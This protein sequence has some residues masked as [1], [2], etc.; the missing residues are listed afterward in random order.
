MNKPVSQEVNFSIR[1]ILHI[2]FLHKGK[3]IGFFLTVF[4]LNTVLTLVKPETY[5][6]YSKLLI[7]IGRENVSKDP[8]VVGDTFS[9]MQSYQD[10]VNSELAILQSQ[11]LAEAVVDEIGPERFFEKTDRAAGGGEGGGEPP[12][13]L[14]KTLE[15]IVNGVRGA[16][17]N[18]LIALNLAEA[19]PVR[20]RALK[21]FEK[22]LHVEVLEDTSI[23]WVSFT[24]LTP[25]T[26]QDTL[27]ALIQ[28]FLDQH[29]EVHRTQASPVFFEAQV[30]NVMKNLEDKES[31]LE[32]FRAENEIASLEIQKNEIIAQTGNLQNLIDDASGKISSYR[33]KVD[34]LE[35][36]LRRFPEKRQ[37]ATVEGKI[38]A[39]AATIK[40]K[41]VE[42][43]L[44]EAE[45][46]SK[47]QEDYKPIQDIR[48]QIRLA[49]SELAKEEETITETTTG[50][51]E[52]YQSMLFLLETTK[53][54]L[55]EQVSL[56][57]SLENELSERKRELVALT[58]KEKE[59]KQLEREIEILEAEYLKYR[60][61]LQ[62]SK[63]STALD[64]DRVSNVSI[65][66][67]ATYPR[68]PMEDGTLFNIVFGLFLGL[69]GGLGLAF[70]ANSFDHTLKTASDVERR[71]QLPVLTSISDK[72][73]KT[74]I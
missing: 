27:A 29:I 61:N 17:E 36:S 47:Y 53:A 60:D 42:L 74:C 31:A 68:L 23:I 64:M 1:E 19:V 51:D 70:L 25:G 33:A 14:V 20:E 49:E 2:V 71:L 24:A 12:F 43:R 10:Q 34:S 66:Q 32:E 7:K 54:D 8:S 52:N 40:T 62:L 59:L 38:N 28:K 55:E 57:N 37:L 48:E 67:G 46:L 63:I 73:F 4:L 35:K 69:F 65:V 3:I 18:T 39:T 5:M 45:L 72:E 22:K 41:L 15:K 44:Q 6:S 21:F 58:G 16:V 56:R 26:A 13:S 50:L 11:D 30:E 9:V